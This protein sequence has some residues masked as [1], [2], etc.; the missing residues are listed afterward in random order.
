[1]K[2]TKRVIASLVAAIMVIT[3][4]FTVNVFAAE[5]VF[6][7]VADDYSYRSA[8]YSLVEK[9]VING[10]EENGQLYFKPE[11]T[12]TRAEFA[13]M[14]TV[15]LAGPVTLVET[16]DKFPDVAL[17]HWANKYIAYAVKAGII[18]GNDDG[19]FRPENPVTYGEAV[20]MIVC[21]KG[22]GSLYKASNPWYQGYIK[23]ANDVN[24]TKNA[25]ALGTQEA[26]RGM[27]AQLIYNMDYCKQITITNK[28]DGPEIDL[29][30]DDEL[31]EEEGVL[32]GVFETT[33]T[34]EGMGLNKFEVM[35]DD[36]IYNIGD[37]E[38][39]KFYPL[40]GKCVEIEYED[41]STPIIR[42]IYES[43]NNPKITIPAEDISSIDGRTIEYYKDGSNRTT[44]VKLSNTG[45]YV[46]YNGQG[47][48][49]EDID[50]DFIEEYFDV[51]CGEITLMNNDGGSDYEIAYITSY[52]TYFV[53]G[54]SA[55]KDVYTF[56][57]S[58]KGRSVTLKNDD[59]DY[60]AYKVTT[61]GGNK[62]STTVSNIGTNKV[63]LSVAEP[64]DGKGVTE[65][66]VSTATLKNAEVDEMSGY[67]YV[68]INDKEYSVS[69]YYKELL[70]SDEET[71]GFDVGDKATFYLDHEGRIVF[72]AKTESTE[73][74]A[75]V[76]GYDGGKGLDSEK[77]LLLYNIPSSS[78][79]VCLIGE[80]VKV[81]GSSK[82]GDEFVTMLKESAAVINE[83]Q[84][85]EGVEII[86]GDYAQLIKYST[87]T[88]NGK[89]YISEASIVDAEDVT[90]GNIVPG[91]FRTDSDDDKEPFSDGVSTLKYNSS[92]KAFTDD[93]GA[94]QF[95]INSSTTVLLVPS[96]R[97]DEEEFKKRTYSYFVNTKSYV[98]EP[99]DVTSNIAKAVIVYTGGVSNL[100]K[101]EGNTDVAFVEG[102]STATNNGERVNKITYYKFGETETKEIYTEDLNGVAAGVEPGDVIRMAVDDGEV[103]GIQIV[104]KDGVLYDYDDN[105]P[106]DEFPADDNEIIHSYNTTSDYYRVVL[107]TVDYVDVDA[108]TLNVVPQIVEDGDEY[109][110]DNWEPF[111]I[112]SSVKFY[113][114]DE[115]SGEFSTEASLGSLNGAVNGDTVD[116]SVASEVLVIMMS[117]SVK[118][119]FILDN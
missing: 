84:L 30:D 73:P 109:D 6:P 16:T 35:I 93:S 113:T 107:G 50:T 117:R 31:E 111:T 22:Y 115:D 97:T 80:N 69:K 8:I 39:D 81:N 19:T 66:I 9:G 53:T 24:L 46:I 47:V 112:G 110:N 61:A 89:T 54:R 71:Y 103:V 99:Y 45:L 108:G 118:A 85:D 100:V 36:T 42:T 82:T 23:I 101:V 4:L 72:M 59:D 32:I 2:S 87:S 95:V 15:A 74:Y 49:Q 116:A 104:Y 56:N 77:A 94:N 40:L 11:N 70:D 96:D 52:D 13:K 34:G 65:A 14:I 90:D 114:F 43:G 55:N 17:D 28:D 92:T 76:L 60:V 48:P 12:I 119:V 21:A 68:V 102:V 75:Y 33:L 67:D 27:V 38:L 5:T 86:D 106:Y 62:A 7:D 83:K 51:E 18:N 25:Q 26:P 37:Y 10:I 41:A 3:S 64:I 58:Y 29:G 78:T 44:D 79:T 98:V 88:K 20:K 63:V 105:T 1:M 91:N 57:D